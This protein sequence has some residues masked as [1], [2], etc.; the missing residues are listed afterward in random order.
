M[1][2]DQP[3]PSIAPPLRHEMDPDDKRTALYQNVI[4]AIRAIPFY[5]HSPINIEGLEAGDLFSLNSLLGGAIEIQTV[6]TLNRIR[7][8]WD[9]NDEWQDYGFKRFPQSY[10]DVRLVRGDNHQSPAIGIELKG[11]YL[12]SKEAEPSFRYKATADASS[13]WDL[14]VC[15]PWTLNNVL[16]GTPEVHEP[17]IEQA[18]HV[19]DMRTFYWQHLRAGNATNRDTKIS[20]PKGIQPYPAPGSAISDSPSSDRGTNFGR[21]ARIQGLMTE[22]TNR[23]LAQSISGIPAKYWIEF[24][25]AF[26]ESKAEA[27]LQHKINGL[28][29]KSRPSDRSSEI[30][31]AFGL[32]IELSELLEYRSI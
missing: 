20:T 14:L 7:S 23:L 19:A 30:E 4:E 1:N 24:L 10:P 11:W 8:V 13:V 6:E 9:P 25:K 17:Y 32:L 12:L 2:A 29:R 3:P 31:R 15:V 22:W 21:I 28:V 5:F 27:D 18:K 16:S 26:T